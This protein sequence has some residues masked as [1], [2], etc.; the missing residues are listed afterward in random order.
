MWTL[1][2]SSMVYVEL[3]QSSMVYVDTGPVQYSLCRHW[4]S[5]KVNILAITLP[6]QSQLQQTVACVP[7]SFSTSLQTFFARLAEAAL[8]RFT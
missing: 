1:D 3:D 5:Q 4:T 2:L 6:A 7:V 8:I